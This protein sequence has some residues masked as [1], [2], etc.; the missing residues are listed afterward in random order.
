MLIEA[1][2]RLSQISAHLQNCLSDL[3]QTEGSAQKAAEAAH[4]A[5]SNAA[6]AGAAVGAHGGDKGYGFDYHH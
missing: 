1:K 3:H 5:Q 6:A 2:Q 4:L